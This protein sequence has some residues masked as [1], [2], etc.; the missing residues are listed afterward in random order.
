MQLSQDIQ[1]GEPSGDSAKPTPEPNLDPQ[2]W[3]TF[4]RDSH[5]ALDDMID[6]VAAV[7]GRKFF[8]TCVVKCPEHR[9]QDAAFL[10]DMPAMLKS[11]TIAALGRI[12]RALGLD[13][14][15][16]DFGIGACGEVV[17]FEANATMVVKP[18]DPDE[19]WAYRGPAVTR[20][21]DAVGAMLRERAT[22][23]RGLKP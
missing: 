14:A 11:E 9:A 13:Y 10:D 1:A 4:R 23:C 3:D 5:R 15:G 8:R 12:V 18:P 19:R 22:G 2:D 20:I 21:L 7:R 17:L 16:I 6:H